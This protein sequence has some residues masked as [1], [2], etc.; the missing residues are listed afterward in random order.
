MLTCDTTPLS[1]YGQSCQAE[2]SSDA[3]T[4]HLVTALWTKNR[5]WEVEVKPAEIH[6]RI[7]TQYDAYNIDQEKMYLLNVLMQE[8]QLT[9]AGLIINQY[10][11]KKK[12][13][14]DGYIA[15]ESPKN[16]FSTSG[17]NRELHL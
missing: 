15:Q 1:E 5:A 9:K 10:R 8:E 13:T 7:L 16:H 6:H 3:W 12:N 2:M 4:L 17:S 11:G 14:Q